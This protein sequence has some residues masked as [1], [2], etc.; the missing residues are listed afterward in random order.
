LEEGALNTSSPA[1]RLHDL[2]SSCKLC[3][4]VDKPLIKYEAYLKWLPEEVKV[5]A[6]GES[7]PPGLKESVFYNTSRFDRFRE[8]MKLVSGLSGDVEVLAFFKSRGVFI[9]GAVKCRPL[10]RKAVEEMRRNCLPRLKA[11]LDL[12]LPPRVVAMGRAAASS[13]SNLLGAEPP[14]SMVEGGRLK[15]N[16]LEVYFT[17]HPNYVLRFRRDLIPWL[18]S[19]ILE[20][21]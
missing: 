8:C 2:I 7:P 1:L 15:V 21:A 14:P 19:L 17:P 13:I 16:G 6:I 11:E 3:S 5:L 9:T 4:F 18:R 10:S 12:L 20:E